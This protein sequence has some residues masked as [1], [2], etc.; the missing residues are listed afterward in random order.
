MDAFE[1]L[2]EP[3]SIANWQTL[4]KLQPE[5]RLV[6]LQAVPVGRTEEGHLRLQSTAVR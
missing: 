3:V 2:A 5:E 1:T 6:F 4:E